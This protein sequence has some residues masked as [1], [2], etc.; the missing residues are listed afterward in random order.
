MMTF[1]PGCHGRSQ[2]LRITHMQGSIFPEI[3]RYQC[4]LVRSEGRWVSLHLSSFFVCICNFYVFL[5]YISCFC[6]TEFLMGEHCVACRCGTRAT[7]RLCTEQAPPTA[8]GRSCRRQG[9]SSSREPPSRRG[10][11][12]S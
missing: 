7:C 9:S 3:Q 12:G 1:L 10:R 2:R 8:R 6:I 4:L 5:I 11:E